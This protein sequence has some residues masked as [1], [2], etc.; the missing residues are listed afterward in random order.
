MNSQYYKHRYCETCRLS[1]PAKASHCRVCGHC[2]HGWDHHC[3]A[4]NNCI[5]RRNIRAFV[6]FLIFSTLFAVMIL[7]SSL[8]ILTI[9]SD[10]SP[11]ST[12]L[13][14]GT[15]TGLTVSGITFSLILNARF[16]NTCRL[17]CLIQGFIISW[18]LIIAFARDPASVL[19]TISIN[20]ALG[21]I[22]LIKPMLYMYIEFVSRHTTAKEEAARNQSSK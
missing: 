17:M 12:N 14:I 19:A 18:A 1:R 11:S 2:V 21:Y 9:D 22:L 16:N 7:L 5:G 10:Y 3:V 15:A 6:S 4:L 20:I 8:L 13:K